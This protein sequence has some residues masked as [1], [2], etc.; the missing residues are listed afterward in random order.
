MLKTGKEELLRQLLE[1][2]DWLKSFV[3]HSSSLLPLLKENVHLSTREFCQKLNE[4]NDFLMTKLVFR[5]GR[6]EDI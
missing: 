3:S 2:E 5:M 1:K 6:R 4:E